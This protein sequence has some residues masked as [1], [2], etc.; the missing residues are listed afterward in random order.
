MVCASRIKQERNENKNNTRAGMKCVLVSRG[1][2][3][4]RAYSRLN[5]EWKYTAIFVENMDD[6]VDVLTFKMRLLRN[7]DITQMSNN[8]RFAMQC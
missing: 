6:A 5:V 2:E 3:A 1:Y 4:E 7:D 8:N